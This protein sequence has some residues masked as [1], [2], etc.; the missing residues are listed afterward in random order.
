MFIGRWC[1][2]FDFFFGSWILFDMMIAWLVTSHYPTSDVHLFITRLPYYTML[3]QQMEGLLCP[4]CGPARAATH[5]SD[6]IINSIVIL[7]VTSS[8]LA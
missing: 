6:T 8:L 3:D 2:R 7:V 4:Y 1:F 5:E